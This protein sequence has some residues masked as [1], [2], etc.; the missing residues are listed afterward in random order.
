MSVT[1]FAALCLV[2]L[3]YDD[4]V[5]LLMTGND[6]LCDALAIVDDKIF[7][8]EVDEY[9]AHLSAVVGINGSRSV[10]HRQSVLQ[11]QSAARTDLCLVTLGQCDVQAGGNQTALQGMQ[12]D[13]RI[14]IGTQVHAGTLRRGICGQLLMPTIYYL[15]LNHLETFL[16]INNVQKYVFFLKTPYKTIKITQKLALFALFACLSP[17]EFVPLHLLYTYI[18]NI[19]YIK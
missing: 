11:G 12:R 13:G 16:I 1:S 9:D 3:F 14:Q 17:L 5:A 19:I 2:E 15:N 10:Q 4:E 8:R 7:G 18:I 6:H